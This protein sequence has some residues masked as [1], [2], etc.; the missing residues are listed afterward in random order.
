MI[1]DLN[2]SFV[3]D[4]ISSHAYGPQI[5]IWRSLNILFFHSKALNG[6]IFLYVLFKVFPLLAKTGVS[7]S[8]QTLFSEMILFGIGINYSSLYV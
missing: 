6:E 8:S 5:K 2:N 7:H 3:R 4:I 1:K